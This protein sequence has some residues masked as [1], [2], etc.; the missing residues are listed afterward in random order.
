VN[1]AQYVDG[2]EVDDNTSSTVDH[3]WKPS[4]NAILTTLHVKCVVFWRKAHHED[5]KE[6]S[7]CVLDIMIPRSGRLHGLHISMRQTNDMLQNF[8][9]TMLVCKGRC[10]R[11]LKDV[12]R[13]ARGKN[14]RRWR[15]LCD[16]SPWDISI[17]W[18]TV[19]CMWPG[20]CWQMK[21]AYFTDSHG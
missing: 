8:C 10:E 4:R 9:S 17:H 15:C 3:I 6:T 16:A 21:G 5:R 14:T 1:E 12:K 7:V 20:Q 19:S 2:E 18:L 13:T 11:C